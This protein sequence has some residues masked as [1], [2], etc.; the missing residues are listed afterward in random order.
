MRLIVCTFVAASL[1]AIAGCAMG[2]KENGQGAVRD[3]FHAPI[4][5]Q[6]AYRRADAYARHCRTST[7]WFKGS[8]QVDGNLYADNQTGVI[9]ITAHGPGKDLERIEIAAAKNGGSDVTVTA[10][11]IGI[12][13]AREIAA[14]RQSIETGTPVCR[15]DLK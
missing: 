12:W 8:F 2:I 3:S 6:E 1:L 7:N 4:T 15:G 13:D 10:W 9:H 14:A 5:Y 11:G